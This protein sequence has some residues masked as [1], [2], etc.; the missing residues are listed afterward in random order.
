MYDSPP[1]R[2]YLFCAVRSWEGEY[3]SRDGGGRVITTTFQSVLYSIAPNGSL[4]CLDHLG[5]HVE[6]PL[7]SPSGWLYYQIRDDGGRRILRCRFDGNT[8]QSIAGRRELNVDVADVYGLS[9]SRDGTT[10]AYTFADGARHRVIRARSDGSNP[11]E[12]APGEPY[13]YMTTLNSDGSYVAFTS[14]A[15]DYRL[16]LSG[17]ATEA[18]IILTPEHNESFWPRFVDCDSALVFMRRDGDLYRVDLARRHVT[19]L[20]TGVAYTE[21]RLSGADSH[22]STDGPHV[23]PTGDLIAFISR[24]SGAPNVWTMRTDGSDARR[25]TDRDQGCGR[26]QFLS[27]GARIAFVSFEADRPQPFQVDLATAHVS[28]VARL[29][30]ACYWLASG[31]G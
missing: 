1:L 29:P 27:G 23:S 2:E 18:P 20:T 24:K 28:A 8:V 16:M 26:V 31:S 25:L 19:R 30:G 17:G 7:V 22:G 3:F 6:Y 21:F 14:P 15:H 5:S 9:I 11:E 10:I 12:I 4:R 13:G